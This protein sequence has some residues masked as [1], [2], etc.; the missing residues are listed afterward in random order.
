MY[1]NKDIFSNYQRNIEMPDLSQT[2][3][4]KNKI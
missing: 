1:Q 3:N 4:M 2:F